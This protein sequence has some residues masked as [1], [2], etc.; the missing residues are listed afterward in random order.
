MVDT[1]MVLFWG[2]VNVEVWLELHKYE[3]P[4]LAL[5]KVNLSAV[6]FSAAKMYKIVINIQQIHVAQLKN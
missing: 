1:S 3:F 5:N 6:N 2:L 4:T